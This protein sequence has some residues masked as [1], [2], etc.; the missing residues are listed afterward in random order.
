MSP[1]LANGSERRTQSRFITNFRAAAVVATILALC[2]AASADDRQPIPSAARQKELHDLLHKDVFKDE[3]AAAKTPAQQQEFA[4]TLLAKAAESTADRAEQFVVLEEARDLAIA[5]GDIGVAMRACDQLNATFDVDGLKMKLKAL[6]AIGKGRLT[7][8]QAK[9]LATTALGLIG[10]AVAADDFAAAQALAEAAQTAARAGGDKDLLRQVAEHQQEVKDAAVAFEKIKKARDTLAASPNEPEANLAIGE[11]KCFVKGEWASGIKNLLKSSVGPLRAAAEKESLAP[12]SAVA[13][14]RAGDAWWD[15][16]AG[17][18][19]DARARI[20]AHAVKLYEV[21]LPALTG[22]SKEKIEKRLGDA[23]RS[24]EGAVLCFAFEKDDYIRKGAQLFLKDHSG[25]GNHG[26]LSGGGLPTPQGKVGAAL[27]FDGKQ[28]RIQV[29]PSASLNWQKF[30]IS[31]WV[32]FR[33]NSDGNVNGGQVLLNKK[34]AVR[35]WVDTFGW[36]RVEFM[37]S[38]RWRGITQDG[39]VQWKPTPGQWV[40]LIAEFDGSKVRIYA[41]DKEVSVSRDIQDAPKATNEPL[42][43]GEKDWTFSSPFN[44]AID[45]LAIYDRALTDNEIARLFRM[46]QRQKS[47]AAK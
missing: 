7:H 44:G 19:P 11:Y 26:E 24:P 20:Q 46:G 17:E 31:M 47:I 41:D 5:G 21:A 9:T 28:T 4:Q 37:G 43:I 16:A 35:F 2:S 39:G 13:Q 27:L 42:V 34:N 8:A 18:P 40:H 32:N 12:S 14:A 6:K 29:A 22:L 3:F 23:A 1:Q 36:L 38:D 33:A 15:L 10:S 45:E 25:N 30:T